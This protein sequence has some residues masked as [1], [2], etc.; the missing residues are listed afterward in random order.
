MG[1]TNYEK[2]IRRGFVPLLISGVNLFIGFFED[3]R[4]IALQFSTD[5]VQLFRATKREV[6]PLLIVNLNLSPQERYYHLQPTI[7]NLDTK[8]ET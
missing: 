8:S 3:E 2:S 1:R 4:T 7:I 6:W 5:G